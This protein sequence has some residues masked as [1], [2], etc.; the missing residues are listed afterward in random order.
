[1]ELVLGAQHSK[2]HDF[3]PSWKFAVVTLQEAVFR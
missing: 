3:V 1:M 2:E